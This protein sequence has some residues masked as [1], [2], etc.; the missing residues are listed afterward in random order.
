MNDLGLDKNMGELLCSKCKQ[1][2]CIVKLVAPTKF[3]YKG[4]SRLWYRI[5]DTTSHITARIETICLYDIQYENLV[6]V[7]VENLLDL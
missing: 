1:V 7:T 5:F 6:P 2:R 4:L 3:Y